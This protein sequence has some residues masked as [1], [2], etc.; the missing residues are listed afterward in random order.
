MAS[1][2]YKTTKSMGILKCVLVINLSKSREQHLKTTSLS[3]SYATILLLHY[4]INN[5]KEI[6]SD[7]NTY[8]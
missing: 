1:E 5:S 2:N 7:I 3:E 8:V 6:L 4:E